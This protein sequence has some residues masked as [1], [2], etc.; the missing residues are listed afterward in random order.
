MTDYSKHWQEGGCK[1]K[2][3]RFPKIK[4]SLWLVWVSSRLSNV[5]LRI[6]NAKHSPQG[7][8]RTLKGSQ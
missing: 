3:Q 6:Y 7:M 8:E 1:K 4:H 5:F 2:W